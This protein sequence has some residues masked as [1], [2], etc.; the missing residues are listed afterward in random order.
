MSAVISVRGLTK[1]IEKK[2]VLSDVSFTIEEGRVVGLLGP[3]GA[4]KTTLMKIL[5]NIFHADAGEIQICAEKAGFETKRHISYMP[6]I[7]H[8]FP[9]MRVRDAIH[10]YSDMFKDF[11]IGRSKELCTFLGINEE[12]KIKKLSKGTKERVLIMLTFS[13]NARLYLLDEPLG[14]IDPLT[15]TKI[16]K[17]IFSGASRGSTIMISTHLVADVETLLD[18]VLFLNNGKLIFSDSA[19]H[20]REGRRMSIEECYV[21]VFENA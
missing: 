15:R 6:D 9:W 16:V 19:D 10:Y 18:D 1:N 4:G 3:N 21:E 17:T 12:E 13:R 8:L 20:I 7:N 2:Q 14:G 5:M 11:D